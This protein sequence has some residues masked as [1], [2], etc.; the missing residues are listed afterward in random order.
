MRW[1]TMLTLLPALTS[2]ASAQLVSWEGEAADHNF[3]EHSWVE[4]GANERTGL[5]GGDWLTLQH[6]DSDPPPAEGLFFATWTI[7]VPADSRYHLWV[8]EWPRSRTLPCR[9]R[10]DDQPWR[11]ASPD[12]PTT[13]PIEL[14]GNRVAAWTRF[15]VVELSAGNHT[16][17]I[18]VPVTA[19]GI[20]AYDVLVLSRGEFKPNGKNPP[21]ADAE[22]FYEYPEAQQVD[23]IVEKAEEDRAR[24]AAIRQEAADSQVTAVG[25]EQVGREV[26]VFRI[27]E[28]FKDE[29]EAH[30]PDGRLGMAE[31]HA[32]FGRGQQVEWNFTAPAAGD[33]IL[34][35]AANICRLPDRTAK[36]SVQLNGAWQDLGILVDDGQYFCK[37]TLPTGPTRFR[38][39][40]HG[41]G[42]FYSSGARLST[43]RADPWPGTR[44]GEHPR[45][46]FTAEEIAA[47]QK[48]YEANPDHPVRYARD[49]LM[50][51]ATD[52]VARPASLN[53][54]RPSAQA[55]HEVAIAY[56]LTGRK[57]FG[58]RGADYL[59]R[60]SERDFG[61]SPGSVLGNGEYLDSVAWGYDAL[62]PH[63]SDE[64][65]TAVRRR[66]DTEAHWLWVQATALAKDTA[67]YWW[68]SDHSNNWQAVSAGGLGMAA[69]ALLGE[70]NDAELWLA[71]AIHQQRLLL[72][73]G[74]D[75]DG[76]YFESPMYQGYATE[77]LTAFASALKREGR[78]DL[79]AE[80][81]EAIRGSA[82]YSLFL[83][84]PTRALYA[85]FNDGHRLAGNPPSFIHPCAGYLPRIADV[86]QDGLI[87]WLFDAMYGPGRRFPVYNYRHGYPD[88]V[89]YY[90]LDTPVEDPDTSKRIDLA[91]VWPD[92]GRAVLRTG[93]NDPNGILF[94]MEC[95]AFGSHGHADQGGFVLSAYG[96]HLIDDA[97]YGGWE[98]TSEAHSVPLIDGQGQKNGGQLGSIRDFIHTPAIDTYV[99]DMAPAYDAMRMD[100]H[101]IWLRP[102]VFVLVDE[103][104]KD[105]QPHEYRWLLHSQVDPPVAA[106]QVASPKAARIQGPEAAVEVRLFGGGEVRAQAVAKNRH[107][108]LQVDLAQ[109]AVRS[110]WFALLQPL[111]KGQ[112]MPAVT[113]LTKGE[114]TGFAMGSDRVLWHEGDGAWESGGLATD[115]RLAAARQEPVS[116]MVRG[117]TSVKWQALGLTSDQTLTAVLTA[118]EAR[119]VLDK[120]ARVTLANGYLPGAKVYATDQDRDPANDR[121]VGQVGAAG[122]VEL[123]AGAV[124]IRR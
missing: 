61:R 99:A 97:G 121:Q 65:R 93:W 13:N 91:R 105:E 82:L 14:A 86:Y 12:Y 57:D 110:V 102:G 87:R 123:A 37:V 98:A 18:E 104:Q 103:L 29:Y 73:G 68:S 114:L 5:S 88:A 46:Q 109:S 2:C 79:F 92:H 71:E 62:Y 85:A 22:T 42:L 74:F 66:L 9:W 60:L 8:R 101:V 72:A 83:M 108:F 32:T 39:A 58:D 3:R 45:L 76:A 124:T 67:T 47:I 50:K 120:P 40:N 30:H 84:E 113:D 23:N 25:F 75:D 56:A 41:G 33:Y 15:G 55:L 19:R 4:M 80:R 31:S 96:N 90:K 51:A 28:K 17:R 116:V 16:F 77:Y 100:R 26:D 44:P 106:I 112:P 1:A 6:R 63:L 10:F 107:K 59:Q 11:E 24:V 20:T 49:G 48:V 54:P 27:G 35:V 122:Q 53:G 117:A 111:A 119:L 38:L 7:Q 52:Q 21:T 81:N 64:L 89:V 43:V 95:G 115:A 94:A 70:S 118:E 36:V 69:L 34:T 78:E